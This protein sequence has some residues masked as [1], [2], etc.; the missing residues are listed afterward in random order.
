MKNKLFLT[1]A[2]IL[3]VAI[4][5]LSQETGSYT[6]SRDGKVYKTVKIGSQTWM[7]EN[8]AYKVDSGCWA[9]NNDLNNVEIYGYLY[10]FEAAK[11]ACPTGWHL[12]SNDE[13]TTLED[14]LGGGNIAGEKL[15]KCDT[16][17]WVWCVGLFDDQY[18]F[19]A[20]PGGAYV[21]D[22]FEGLG[23]ECLFWTTTIDA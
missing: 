15:I 1:T 3:F 18:K 13:W 21:L 7:A 22:E 5:S 10:D 20:L 12:P 17:K 16:T 8:L 14:Y 4:C 9:Y 23:L 11:K 19:S 6:D 2:A